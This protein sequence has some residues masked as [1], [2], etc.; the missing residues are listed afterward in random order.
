MKGEIREKRKELFCVTLL[1]IIFIIF[2]FFKFECYI[3]SLYHVDHLCK[4]L[5]LYTNLESFYI[6]MRPTK[7]SGVQ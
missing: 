6:L 5:N 1:N 3:V 4:S 2:V 7:I